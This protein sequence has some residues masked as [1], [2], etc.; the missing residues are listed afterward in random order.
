MKFLEM[1]GVVQPPEITP[2]A[3]IEE[4]NRGLA[5]R[6]EKQRTIRDK[7]NS[8]AQKINSTQ[9][10]INGLRDRLYALYGTTS[11]GISVEEGDYVTVGQ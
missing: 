1:V 2:S 11:G 7:W 6:Y 5:A 3:Q 4:I 10:D 8:R 9:A